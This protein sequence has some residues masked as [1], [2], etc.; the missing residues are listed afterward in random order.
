MS[1]TTDTATQ[2]GGEATANPEPA[3]TEA[4][5]TAPADTGAATDHDQQTETTERDRA[6]R[7]FAQMSARLAQTAQERDQAAARIAQLEAANRTPDADF[8]RAVEAATE[9]RLAARHAK[10]RADAFH[11][12]GRA[13]F[14]DWQ[15][16]CQALMAM[17]ADAQMSSLLVEMKDGAKV[18]AALHDDPDE[19][20]R[21]ARL[22]TPTARA[23]A[24]GV[25][26]GRLDAAGSGSPPSR[27]ETG[28]VPG[29]AVSRAPAPIRPVQG[30]ANP[31]FNEYTAGNASDGNEALVDYYMKAD[32][33]RRGLPG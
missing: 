3:A 11:E 20:E 24:L 32:R 14:P 16:R 8:E 19:L 27:G 25:Y 26:A 22:T 21:I 12:A 13:Q 5:A 9:Q 4:E 33:L 15:T 29:R 2:G 28:S 6:A 1:E 23:I 30:R 17:G 18:A 31:Q 10:E 7:R